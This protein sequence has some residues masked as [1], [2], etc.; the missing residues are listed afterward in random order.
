MAEPGQG[1]IKPKTAKWLKRG[2]YVLLGLLLIL[3]F[4]THKHAAFVWEEVPDF[5][6]AYGLAVCVFL[7][8]AAKGLR[9]LLRRD[10]GYYDT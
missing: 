8:F 5:Y 6:A 3:D 10:E 7:V 2:F 1:L 4:F 9:R